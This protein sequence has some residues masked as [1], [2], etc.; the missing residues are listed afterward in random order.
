MTQLKH[1]MITGTFLNCANSE[2]TEVKIY[3]LLYLNNNFII[4]ITCEL[5]TKNYI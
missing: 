3:P 5:L 4:F 2:H 1:D